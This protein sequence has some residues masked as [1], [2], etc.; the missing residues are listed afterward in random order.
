MLCIVSHRVVV[1][2]TKSPHTN[3]PFLS[4]YF[5]FLSLQGLNLLHLHY[6]LNGAMLAQCAEVAVCYSLRT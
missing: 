1:Q 4:W 5:V 6:L 3:F 2:E